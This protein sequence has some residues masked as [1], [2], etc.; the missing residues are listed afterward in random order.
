MIVAGALT[1]AMAAPFDTLLTFLNTN[2]ELAFGPLTLGPASGPV[3][4]RWHVSPDGGV[5]PRWGVDGKQIF[6]VADD[7]L[8][9]LDLELQPSPRLGSPGRCS[10]A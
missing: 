1:A 8:M 5:Q 3:G 6:F 4:R 9:V 7:A 10:P 2:T